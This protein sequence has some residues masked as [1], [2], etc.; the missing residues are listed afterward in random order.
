MPKTPSEVEHYISV[1]RQLSG[2]IMK[3]IPDV[4]LATMSILSSEYLKIKY[5]QFS[6]K[7]YPWQFPIYYMELISKCIL[8][9]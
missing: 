8:K 6:F 4:M 9:A 3:N 5:V 7:H 1:F 2:D